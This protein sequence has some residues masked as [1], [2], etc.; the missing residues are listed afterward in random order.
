MQK[1]NDFALPTLENMEQMAKAYN[2][3]LNNLKKE[4]LE[5]D[6]TG[7]DNFS[8]D[9]SQDKNFQNNNEYQPLSSDNSC[10]N[11][12]SLDNK[13]AGNS[14]INDV[15][16]I[17]NQQN[18]KTCLQ[19]K[20]HFTITPMQAQDIYNNVCQIFYI[21]KFSLKHFNKSLQTKQFFNLAK[22]LHILTQ[23]AFC[24]FILEDVKEVSIGENSILQDTCLFIANIF[25]ILFNNYNNEFKELANCLIDIMHC[26]YKL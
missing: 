18:K 16:D 1:Y 11:E 14:A 3:Q 13:S 26:V 25:S 17:Y 4:E 19:N 6:N 7:Y 21:A 10:D 20:S 23:S 24:S 9:I 5:N 22:R 2:E 15:K 8:L 12:N